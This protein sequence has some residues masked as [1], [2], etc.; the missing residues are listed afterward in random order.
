MIK[1]VRKL[2]NRQKAG[3]IIYLG[4]ALG[5]AFLLGV[6]LLIG[7][8][9][10]LAI[11]AAP[12][13]QAPY[14]IQDLLA[15]AQSQGVARVIVGLNIP[16]Q[17]EGDLTD[18]RAVQNQR[19]DI[20]T[21]Q[22]AVLKK[23]AGSNT[24]LVARFKYIPY[25]ALQVDAAALVTLAALPEVTSIEEDGFD[26]PSLASSIPVIGADTA[27]AAGYTGAGQTIAILDTGVD[28]THPFFST[29]GQKVVSEACYSTN[30]PSVGATS[31]CLGSVTETTAP[32]SGIDC[33]S[34]TAGLPTAEAFCGHGTHVAGIA[35]GN[36]GGLNIGVARDA[37][38]IAIQVF[39]LIQS[40]ALCGSTSECLLSDKVDQIK[41][42][43]RAYELRNDFNI[44]AVNISLGSEQNFV[45]CDSA[46]LARKTAIDLLRSVNIATVIA[47]GNEGYRDAI[48]APACISSAV[49]VGAT[50]D[51]DMIAIFSNV[52]DFLDL[53]APGVAITSAV[54]AE[55]VEEMGGTSM[56]VPHVAG[57][58][59]I[60][61]QRA[62]AATVDEVLTALNASGTSVD[63]TRMQPPGTV[64]D[65]RRINIDQALAE[66]TPDL[67]ITKIG[68]VTAQPGDLI[69]Y[70]IVMANHGSTTAT[71]VRITDTLPTSVIGLGLDTRIT[72]TAK[73]SV[74]LDII[75]I[76]DDSIPANTPITN[77]VYYSHPS[78]SGQSSTSFT[79]LRT[80]Y[81]PLVLKP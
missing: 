45:P 40:E 43:E 74:L 23:M 71:N 1:K 2:S 70:T 15:K 64:I 41:G 31:V 50:D 46:Q 17:P 8:F 67:Q 36:D 27:W 54:P 81:L 58:W 22:D 13:T 34:V 9:T 47:S 72:V 38:I 69:T 29:G 53:L 57:A 4:R 21:A 75:A 52:A 66:L 5:L 30:L 11:Q 26:A 14:D 56:A 37:T 79:F 39:T 3:D 6:V 32:G 7:S 73:Q 62:P 51:D 65:M 77:T 35:A 48:N 55:G 59:A 42:L 10:A 28:K 49:S 24:T 20:A 33:T 63:D 12:P 19:R 68:P 44:A 25:M 16:Y 78:G 76:V 80:V 61:K 18:S 60:M